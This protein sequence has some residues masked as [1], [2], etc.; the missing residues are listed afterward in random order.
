MIITMINLLK[1]FY[2]ELW[3]VTFNQNDLS[4]PILKQNN[5]C[6]KSENNLD[7]KTMPQF[8]VFCDKDSN[9]GAVTFTTTTIKAENF[10]H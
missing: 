1:R 5:N 3:I 7:F 9:Y 6:W 4:T 2:L 8:T 10:V